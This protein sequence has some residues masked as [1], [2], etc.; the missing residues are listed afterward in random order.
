MTEE[1]NKSDIN[2]KNLKSIEWKELISK[3]FA[4]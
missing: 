2:K 3:N 4:A 1:I